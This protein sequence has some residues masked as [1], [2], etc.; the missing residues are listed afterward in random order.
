MLTCLCLGVF[1][2]AAY[3]LIDTAIDYNKNRKVLNNLQET[4]Y[5][6]DNPII[7]DEHDG[8]STSIRSGFNKLLKENDEL[9][10]WITVDGT[11]IDYPIL[12]ADNNVDYLRSNFYK[13]KNIAGS[14]FMDY[15]ERRTR[16]WFK[17]DCL[18]PSGEGRFHVRAINKVSRSGL[19]YEPPNVRI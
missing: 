12:Q 19:F 4:F 9:V 13:E 6:A 2:Y 7:D 5:N 1:I 14:I 17:Y 10:G 8:E 18:R 3:G 11:Q 15:Q 16:T